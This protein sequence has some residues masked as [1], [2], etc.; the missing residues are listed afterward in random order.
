MLIFVEKV[1]S[2]TLQAKDGAIGG[3][4]HLCSKPG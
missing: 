2:N 3:Q 4:T 1:G